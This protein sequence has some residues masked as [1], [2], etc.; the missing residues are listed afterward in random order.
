MSIWQ[1]VLSYNKPFMKGE[2]LV[3]LL[4]HFHR[5]YPIDNVSQLLI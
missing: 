4:N 3:R 5:H 1:C 2:L